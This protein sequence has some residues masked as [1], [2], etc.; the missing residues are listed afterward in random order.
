MRRAADRAEAFRYTPL[1][2]EALTP[3]SRVE[4]VAATSAQMNFLKD[5][6][7]AK[8]IAHTSGIANFLVLLDGQLAGGFIYARSKFGGDDLYLLSDFTLAAKAVFPS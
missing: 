8:G 6:Y 3:S 1:D 4:I 5:I 2:P 7:L